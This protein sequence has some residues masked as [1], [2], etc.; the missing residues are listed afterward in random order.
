VQLAH[1]TGWD[2]DIFPHRVTNVCILRE[3]VSG[4]VSGLPPRAV[5]PL[6]AWNAHV[7]VERV[8][9]LEHQLA[10][11]REQLARSGGGHLRKAG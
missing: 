2:A 7:D 3:N 5:G 10:T 6:A 8:K 9:Q 1:S 11:L 4:G